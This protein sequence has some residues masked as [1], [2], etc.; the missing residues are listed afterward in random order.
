MSSSS[1]SSPVGQSEYRVGALSIPSNSD[2]RVSGTSPTFKLDAWFDEHDG[3]LR[4]DFPT[5]R[6]VRDNMAQGAIQQQAR[7]STAAAAVVAAAATISR[8][9]TFAVEPPATAEASPSPSPSSSSSSS[10]SS[11]LSGTSAVQETQPRSD[12]PSLIDREKYQEWDD[13][14]LGMPDL[15]YSLNVS[16]GLQQRWALLLV[17]AILCN[18]GHG[19]QGQPV[20]VTLQA[21]VVETFDRHRLGDCF[22]EKIA[23]DSSVPLPNGI[24]RYKRLKICKLPGATTHH[25]HTYVTIGTTNMSAVFT[26]VVLRKPREHRQVQCGP[27]ASGF[28]EAQPFVTRLFLSK[29]SINMARTHVGSRFPNKDDSPYTS[30]PVTS[31]LRSFFSH[32]EDKCAYKSARAATKRIITLTGMPATV[33]TLANF[34]VSGGM[35]RAS[36]MFLAIAEAMVKDPYTAVLKRQ[37]VERIKGSGE[38]GKAVE[39]LLGLFGQSDEQKVLAND[40]L[41][42]KLRAVAKRLAPVI[43]AQNQKL[44]KRILD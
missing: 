6:L 10:S 7:V 27:Y 11:S 32:F 33:F 3:T 21:L 9:A 34:G 22:A 2:N 29:E 37:D 38:L 42:K 44:E 36:R 31:Q 24:R 19:D 12:W 13:T 39:E 35:K 17:D 18:Q 28:F 14:D 40:E 15:F 41:D 5:K 23:D 1:S 4:I 26:A 25:R 20:Q 43:N 16:E 30:L 8:I